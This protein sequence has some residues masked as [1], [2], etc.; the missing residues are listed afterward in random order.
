MGKAVGLLEL[1]QIAPGY[2]IANEVSKHTSVR[3]LQAGTICPG[4]FLMVILGDTADVQVAMEMVEKLNMQGVL[5]HG[6]LANIDHRVLEAMVE[7][8]EIPR[9]TAIGI[10]ETIGVAPAVLAADGAVKSGAV[11]LVELRL[12]G[13]MAGKALIILAGSVDAVKSALDYVQ[14]SLNPSDIVSAV[15]LASPHPRLLAHWQQ[16]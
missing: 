12:T 1:G 11:E 8:K 3:I 15:L 5:S 7:F 4:G 9:D 16:K 2:L 6:M 10:V 13:G 14:G